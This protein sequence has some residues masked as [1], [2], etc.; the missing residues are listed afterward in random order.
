[1]KLSIQKNYLKYWKVIRQY[2]KTKFKISQA[3]L[4]MLLF[5]YSE[6]YFT[7]MRFR[8]YSR[9]I[10]WDKTRFKRLL[11]NG[12]FE[13][14]R[15]SNGHTRSIY[16]MSDKGKGLVTNIYKKLNGEDLPATV[17]NNP[18]M[19]KKAKYSDKVMLDMIAEMRAF[20]KQ[21]RHLSR[22]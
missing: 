5:M 7:Q 12:W 4:D 19:K 9:I 8:E 6:G 15:K 21:Q 14:F 1:M 10:G 17:C 13:M 16:I 2:Y 11:D 22:E 20:N 18:M 3:D